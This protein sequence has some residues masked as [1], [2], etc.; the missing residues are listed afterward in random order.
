MPGARKF[1]VMEKLNV[2]ET[3]PP[4]MSALCTWYNPVEVSELLLGFFQ[5]GPYP[6]ALTPPCDPKMG[7]TYSTNG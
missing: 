2:W 6:P 5:R 1:Y 7:P 4:G 3:K